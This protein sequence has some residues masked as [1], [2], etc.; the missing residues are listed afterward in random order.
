[1]GVMILVL[2]PITKYLNILKKLYITQIQNRKTTLI[3]HET[4]KMPETRRNFPVA[5]LE[6]CGLAINIA[7]FAHLCDKR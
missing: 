1:M 2:L 7:S 5:E 4:E 3:A 6:L